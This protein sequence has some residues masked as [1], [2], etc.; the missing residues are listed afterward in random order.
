MDAALN[1]WSTAHNPFFNGPRSDAL[2]M[3]PFAAL[4][5]FLYLVGRERLLSPGETR[6]ADAAPTPSPHA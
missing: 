5:V 6:R 1:N 4:A 3:I 2:S